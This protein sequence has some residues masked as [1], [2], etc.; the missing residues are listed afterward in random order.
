MEDFFY[1]GGL[2]AVMKE[3][4]HLLDGDALTVTG[5]TMRENVERAECHRR[6]VIRTAAEPLHAEGGTV[7]LL[8]QSGPGRRGV[9]TDRRITTAAAASRPRVRVRELSADARR[10]SIA[11]T[12]P[13]IAA[14][15][16]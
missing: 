15:C 14:P 13:W 10:R 3:I 2:P 8:R 1:A 4:L 9:Q 7:I 6:E 11:K 12:C 16:W 5:K